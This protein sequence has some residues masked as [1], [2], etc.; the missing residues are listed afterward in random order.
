MLCAVTAAAW[1]VL[2]GCAQDSNEAGKIVSGGAETAAPMPA[3]AR[4]SGLSQLGAP[5]LAGAGGRW[6]EVPGPWR[7]PEAPR[8]EAARSWEERLAK[9]SPSQQ[10]YLRGLNDRYLGVLAFDSPDEQERL[11]RQGFPMPEE[12]LAA[13]DLLDSELE[14]LAKEGNFKAQMLQIDRVGQQVGAVLDAR[15]GLDTERPEHR[16]MLVRLA[17]AKFMNLEMLRATG[18]PF[19]AYQYGQTRYAMTPA[20]PPEYLASSLLLAGDLGDKRAVQFQQQFA[21]KHSDLDGNLL[22]TFYSNVQQLIS[23]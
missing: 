23:P 19:A 1:I 6:L 16:E 4:D 14:A 21:G 9:F 15:G 7:F 22:M 18:S 2:T 13:Q 10:V 17:E 5:A 8:I 3:I 20:R 12:W 11:I